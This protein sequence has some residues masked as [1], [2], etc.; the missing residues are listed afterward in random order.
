MTPTQFILNGQPVQSGAAPAT[1]LVTVLRDEFGLKGTKQG[2]AEGD[3]GICTVLV[4]GAP[5]CACLVPLGRVAGTTIRTVEGLAPAGVASP[6]Q[7]SFRRHDAAQCG[8]CT[9]GMLM[10]ASALLESTPQPTAE[11]ARA[12]LSGVLCRCTGYQAIIEAVVNAHAPPSAGPAGPVFGSRAPRVDSERKVSG[13]EG[14]GADGIPADALWVRLIRSPHHRARLELGDLAPI[15]RAHP[16][17]VRI[18]TGHDFPNNAHGYT[19]SSYDQP[20]LATACVRHFGEPVLALVGPREV[21]AA[22][23]EASLPLRYIPE[24]PVFGVA[25]AQAP[26]APRVQ[27]HRADN[28]LI[29]SGVTSGDPDAAF[30]TCH[31]IAEGQFETPFVEHAYMEPEA[32]WARRVGDRLEIH[33]TTQGPYHVQRL[34]SHLL[35]LPPE[36]VRVLPTAVGGGFGG[37]FDMSVHPVIALAA[38]T[39]NR[40]VACVFERRESMAASTKRHPA[41]ITARLGADAEGRLVAAAVTTELDTGAYTSAGPTVAIRVPIHAAG[42][43]LVPQQRNMARAWFTN[44]TPA[45]GFRGFGIPQVAI[46]HEALMDDLAARLGL[47][48]WEIRRRNALAV[49]DVTCTGQ[50]LTHSA[51]LGACLDA[52]KPRWEGWLA[53]CAAWNAQPGPRRRGVGIGCMW[54]G[55]GATSQANPSTM[56]LGLGPDGAL[57]LYSGVVEL[58][59]GGSTAMVQIAAEALGLPMAAIRLVMGDTDRTLDAGKTSASRQTFISGRATAEACAALRRQLCR[60]TNAGPE[61]AIA[62]DGARVRVSEAGRE[63]VLELAALPPLPGGEVLVAEGHFDPP[64]GMLDASGQ[65]SPYATYAFG[66]QLALVEVDRELGSVQ[67]LKM[68]AAHDVGRAVN[69]AMVE[70]QIRGGIAQGLGFALLEEYRPGETDNLHDYLLPTA[71]D[72][73][74]IECLLIEDPEPLGPFGAKGVGEPA[75]VPTAAAIL[76][77]IRHASGFRA[78]RVPV[79]PHRLRSGLERA[80]HVARNAQEGGSGK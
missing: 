5:L 53:E 44:V 8:F 17:L 13:G 59:Q 23:P 47:D 3:C 4:D 75:L 14:Y 49:G 24:A 79:L 18:F 80:A 54:Y 66:A 26:G 50:R 69:P 6:L 15:L 70:G 51:G 63:Q 38:W 19:P 32:G 65:G 29:Q 76:G 67:V 72:V 12:A 1:R 2:C 36:R 11:D 31:A 10:A 64:A 27:Q 28:L 71:L 74:E 7:D 39:L 56:R 43:Y 21:I 68:A 9:A 37:K 57:T 60:L 78:D 52:L 30:A 62:F 45:G 35:D 73:P 34:V 42:P 61:A 46:A 58:G 25:A 22:V 48:R 16:G 40:P 55:I 77:A 20:A 33:V 41:S